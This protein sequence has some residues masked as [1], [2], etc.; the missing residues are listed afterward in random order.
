MQGT[1]PRRLEPEHRPV[2]S[3]NLQYLSWEQTQGQDGTIL[4]V[5]NHT[6]RCGPDPSHHQL[7]HVSPAEVGPLVDDC[8]SN[9]SLEAVVQEELASTCE[10]VAVVYQD[11]YVLPGRGQLQDLKPDD[12]VVL[13]VEVGGGGAG[14]SPVLAAPHRLGDWDG[15]GQQTAGWRP[16]EAGAC[17][18]GTR[19]H[20]S[21][22]ERMLLVVAVHL[23]YHWLGLHVLY[24]GPRHG[25][26]DVLNMV[27]V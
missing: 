16:G 20:G 14:G 9:P 18:R 3:G 10:V 13:G 27:E 2:V 17:L 24:E 19:S 5:V 22:G 21:L 7:P 1:V 8:E 23:E 15:G 25:D 4:V 11:W 26:C 6:I 12:Q